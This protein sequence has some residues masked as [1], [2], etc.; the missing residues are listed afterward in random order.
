M[1]VTRHDRALAS[2][3]NRKDSDVKHLIAH[4]IPC[5]H[6]TRVERRGREHFIVWRQWL[7]HVW[8]VDD[9]TVA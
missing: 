2:P 9:I 8:D 7:N 1:E 6:R 5:T 3:T 4:L